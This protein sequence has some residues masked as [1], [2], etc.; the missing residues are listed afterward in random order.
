MGDSRIDEQTIRG[1]ITAA[2]LTKYRFAAHHTTAGQITT[3]SGEDAKN[4][5]GITRRTTT[6]GDLGEVVEE[7]RCYLEVNGNSVNIAVG[8]SVK[9]GTSAG[10]GIKADTDK[11]P[12]L[13][14]ALEAATADNVVI[15]VRIDRH[16]VGV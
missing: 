1:Y 4:I 5:A 12:A 9:C 7:G 14:T 13:C 16:D 8:D 2:N 3:P 6:S 10:I 15:V 11:D